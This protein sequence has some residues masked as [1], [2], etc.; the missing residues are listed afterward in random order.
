M[1]LHT[2]SCFLVALKTECPILT[3]QVRSHFITSPSL[4]LLDVEY[5]SNPLFSF[6]FPHFRLVYNAE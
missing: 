2:L 3:L 5:F 4:F 1:V 6:F